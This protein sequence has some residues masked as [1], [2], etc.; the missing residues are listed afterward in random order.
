MGD[1]PLKDSL[2]ATLVAVIWG[3]NFVVI[4][5]GL[6][7][8]MPP[9]LF[10]A[11]RFAV[12]SLAVVVVARPAV[13]FRQVALVGLFMSVGQ[14]GLLYSALAM[15]MPPGL[16][17]LV[18]QAQ[19]VLTVVFAA[20]R[21][22]ERPTGA[23]VVGV[24]LGAVGLGVVALGRSAATPLLA[25]LVTVAAAASWACGNVVARRAGAA[26]G[27]GLTVWSATVVPVP[28]LVL[29]LLL[30]GPAEVGHALTSLSL[31]AVLSTAYT[32]VLAS[33]VGYGIWNSLLARHRTSA[34]VPFTL[35][36]PLVGMVSAWLVLEEVPNAAEA[37][38][39]VVLLLG[40]ATAALGRFGPGGRPGPQPASAAYSAAV[41]ERVDA[42]P[43]RR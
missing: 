24:V 33:W 15:G 19:V 20:V 41:E 17:S 30:D 7:D 36:V 29:S 42:V 22:A 25:L 26:S 37:G 4:D 1:V 35:L 3:V 6:D 23:Q 14:F 9:L 43:G 13:A 12:V 11:L 10:A 32:A 38:G 40:V 27:F 39:G 8:D 34:V 28:L 16:A 21:L 5:A 18:L 2:L 31:A